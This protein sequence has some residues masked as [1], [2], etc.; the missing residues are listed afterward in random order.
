MTW[1][2]VEVGAMDILVVGDIAM[3]LSV[4]P[5]STI[6]MR[7]DY[8]MMLPVIRE[9]ESEVAALCRLMEVVTE[10]SQQ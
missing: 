5:L 9:K 4:A 6:G 8:M 7:R 1:I 3:C 2:L 10:Q